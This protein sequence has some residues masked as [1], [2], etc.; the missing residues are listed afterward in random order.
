MA[1]YNVYQGTFVCHVCRAETKTLRF[2]SET[3]ELTWMCPEK[4]VSTVSLETKKSR[5]DFEREERE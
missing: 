1:K 5:R 3:K 4:H 2:Y